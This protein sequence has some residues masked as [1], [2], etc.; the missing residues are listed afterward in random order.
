MFRDCYR[1]QHTCVDI[2]ALIFS[3]LSVMIMPSP[4]KR[5][6]TVRPGTLRTFWFHSR[7][8]FS[9]NAPNI[10][11]EVRTSAVKHV[12]YKIEI[13]ILNDMFFLTEC[14]SAVSKL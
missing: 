3:M 13:L 14:W 10:E 7:M 4:G 5:T 12:S 11:R 1:S 2:I 8:T 6:S 9:F